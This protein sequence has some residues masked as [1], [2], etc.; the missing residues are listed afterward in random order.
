MIY[1]HTTTAAD[2]R[3]AD[4]VDLAV[5]RLVKR[6]RQERRRAGSGDGDPSGD[7]DSTS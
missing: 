6:D 1:Q 7:D 2:R 3:I 4:G 5:K